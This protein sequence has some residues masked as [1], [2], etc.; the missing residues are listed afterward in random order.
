[1]LCFI[2]QCNIILRFKTVHVKAWGL[3]S[4]ETLLSDHIKFHASQE[5]SRGTTMFAR[6][7]FREGIRAQFFLLGFARHSNCYNLFSGLFQMNTEF[8][9]ALIR[10]TSALQLNGG[11]IVLDSLSWCLCRL[12]FFSLFSENNTSTVDLLIPTDLANR[13]H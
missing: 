4:P 9:F 5:L 7:F 12:L 1:M 3:W 11:S 13:A 8:A 2:T 10:K 6:C